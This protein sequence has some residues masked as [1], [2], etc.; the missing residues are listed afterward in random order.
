MCTR[1][2]IG[3]APLMVLVGAFT[4]AAAT[5]AAARFACAP[6]PAPESRTN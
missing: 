5:F 2:R 4:T 3:L 1:I 6:P